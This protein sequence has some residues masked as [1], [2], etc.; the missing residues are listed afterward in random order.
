VLIFYLELKHLDDVQRHE[1]QQIVNKK[2]LQ[3]ILVE[4]S[5]IWVQNM[6]THRCLTVLRHISDLN[7]EIVQLPPVLS[8]LSASFR[9]KT[10]FSHIQRLHSMLYAYGATI[11]EIVRRKEFSKFFQNFMRVKYSNLMHHSKVLLS[12]RTE[13]T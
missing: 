8:A 9:L 12:T 3:I 1:L 5:L 7:N 13:H 2:V 6:Y 11:I 4:T 10:S